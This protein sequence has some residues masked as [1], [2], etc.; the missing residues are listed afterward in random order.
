VF[1]HSAPAPLCPHIQWAIQHVLGQRVQLDWSAQP[2]GPRLLRT[3]LTWSGAAGTGARI[4]SA[5]RTFEQTRYE[6]TEEPTS[7][8]EGSRWQHTPALGIHRAAIS[9]SGD[10]V[11]SEERLRAALV[12]AESGRD[13]RARHRALRESIDDILGTAWDGELEAFRY[14][15]EG[16]P[17]RWLYRAV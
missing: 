7:L 4:A 9:A 2:A 10:V 3:E 16:A 5:L 1:I 12:A 8:T 14:A 15:G 13:D 17:V 6:V 11:V